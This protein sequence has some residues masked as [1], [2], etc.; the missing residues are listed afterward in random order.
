MKRPDD[1]KQYD[2]QERTVPSHAEVISTEHYDGVI[3]E[4]DGVVT[5]TVELHFESWKETFDA[6][7]RAREGR[8]FIPFDRQEFR[9]HVD[10]KLRKDAIQT[11]L[12]SRNITL[13]MGEPLPEADEA[14]VHDTDSIYGLE[15]FKQAAFDKK[16]ESGQ[17]NVDDESVE[18]L[19]RLVRAGIKIA[20]VSPS[21]RTERIL[22]I[23]DLTGLFDTIVDGTTYEQE[24]LSGKPTEDIFYE[25][26]TRLGITR[27]RAVIIEDDRP[28]IEAGRGSGFG[29]IVVVADSDGTERKKFLARGADLVVDGL[30]TLKVRGADGKVI[31]Q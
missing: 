20:V 15:N 18:L 28:S 13:P 1:S 25:A 10:G 26:A 21:H 12:A 29:L 22:S 3:V 31:R 9:E 14:L 4:L 24:G 19:H 23:L 16:I 11:W 17:L 6:L 7:L 27:D 5:N 30:D 2:D 8:N